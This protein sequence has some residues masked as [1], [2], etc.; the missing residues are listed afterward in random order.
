MGGVVAMMSRVLIVAFA[1]AAVCY[2]AVE[3]PAPGGEEWTGDP[4]TDGTNE[5]KKMDADADGKVTSDEIKDFMRKNYYS[6]EEDIKDLQNDDGKPATAD[7]ITKMIET[8]ASELLT[9]LDKD[10]SG[11]LSLEELIAQYKDMEVD[12]EGEE[13]P[14]EDE[15]EPEA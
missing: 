11:T 1:F 2:C 8:D 5:M 4:V 9:E 14:P 6:N 13:P 10:Q 3:D 12:V 15:P 7:D